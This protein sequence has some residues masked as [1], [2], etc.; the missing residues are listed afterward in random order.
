MDQ[1]T[2]LSR[3]QPG[4]RRALL[5]LAAAAA[6]GAWPVRAQQTGFPSK[7]VRIVVGFPPGG[8]SDSAARILAE[9]L[10]LEWG[11]PVIVEN[12]PG[13]GST[14]ATAQVASSPPDGHTLLLIAPGTHAVSAALFSNL[15]YDPVR[16]FTS[17]T[18]V[19]AGTYFL[20]VNAD[21]PYKTLRDLLDD[22]KARP[23]AVTYASTGNGSGSHLVA[24]SLGSAAGVKFLHTP[25]NGAAPATLA[26][27]GGQVQFAVSDISAIG[28]LQSGKLRALAVTSNRRSPLVP[29]VPTIAEAGVP[30]AEYVLS[31]GLVG[32]AGVPGPVVDQLHAAVSKV[33]AL[34]DVR[35]R[36][37]ALGFDAEPSSPQ[38]YGQTIA[39]DVDKFG[40][41]VRQVGLKTS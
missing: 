3:P 36:M 33:L 31:V 37:A 1:D 38:A 27:L 20:L 26:L 11:S 34:P 14:I 18:Q 4:R 7:T 22:A 17:I 24:E 40:K 10:A 19:G 28:H 23:G 12:K 8:S 29:S 35:Q 9:K 39:S 32:P 21:T 5:A 16:S 25:Y 2:P 6:A 15:S 13:A 41:L 30:Q